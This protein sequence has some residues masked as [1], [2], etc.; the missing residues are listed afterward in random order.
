MNLDDEGNPTYGISET[1]RTSATL[2]VVHNT[3]KPQN[4]DVKDIGSHS[5]TVSWD[6]PAEGFTREYEVD[7]AGHKRIVRA[8][9]GK[10]HY[11]A[12][13]DDLGGSISY[14][15]LYVSTADSR[16]A[17]STIATAQ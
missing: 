8:E 5:V 6:A 11:E 17:K 10:T 1:M 16:K 13:I 9:E 2:P 15:G 3:T 4:L 14:D 12:T 7:L